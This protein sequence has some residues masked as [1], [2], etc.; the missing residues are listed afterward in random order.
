MAEAKARVERGEDVDAVL[1]DVPLAKAAGVEKLADKRVSDLTKLR[2]KVQASD[3][4]DKK[5]QVKAIN[6]EIEGTM[7]L[8]N[9][10]V[11][12]VVKHPA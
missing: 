9:Q 4:P 12:D 7:R 10:A 5:D 6:K 2:R 1:K 11:S 8:L 3:A